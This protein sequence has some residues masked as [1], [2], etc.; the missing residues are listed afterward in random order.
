[1]PR[2]R[3]YSRRRRSSKKSTKRRKSKKMRGGVTTR[4]GVR[5][6]NYRVLSPLKILK[7]TRL[8]SDVFGEI[9]EMHPLFSTKLTNA[10]I[11][12]AVRD[13]SNSRSRAVVTKLFGKI[14]NWDVSNVTDMS[15]AFNHKDC[16]YFN[17]PLNK[18]NVSNVTNMCSMFCGAT[19]FNQPLNKWNVTRRMDLISELVLPSCRGVP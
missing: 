15:H 2:N 3:K 1:M 18:W 13:Y 17:Q 19:S 12:R 7:S 5:R 6:G 8:P 14:E 11:R 9:L 16:K 4:S 10:T